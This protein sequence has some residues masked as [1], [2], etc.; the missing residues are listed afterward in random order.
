MSLDG[1]VRPQPPVLRALSN[2]RLALESQGYQVISWNP[3]AHNSAVEDLFRIIGADGAVNTYT[4]LIDS[5]EPPVPQLKDWYQSFKH[6]PALPTR[7][8][9]TL[10]KKRREYMHAYH[11]YWRSSGTLTEDHCEVD[12]IVM[13]VVA[14]A[15]CNESELTYFGRSFQHEAENMTEQ[16]QVIVLSLTT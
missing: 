9:W 1:Y 10:C 7:E 13:P 2:T 16:I 8:F 12:G 11:T 15:A 14:E 5:A 4:D 3:P 6:I